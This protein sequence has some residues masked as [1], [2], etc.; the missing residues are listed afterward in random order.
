MSRNLKHKQNYARTSCYTF[1]VAL[2]WFRSCYSSAL[3]R[4]HVLFP[5]FALI[6]CLFP[7][8]APVSCFSCA[9]H[10]FHVF[11][12]CYTSFRALHWFHDFPALYAGFI[13]SRHSRWFHVFPVLDTRG[14]WYIR[15]DQGPVS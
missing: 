5:R 4:S 10:C 8:F 9:L 12:I 13:F 6:S 14:Q 1:Y 7:R 15:L 3:N 11:C 2:Q